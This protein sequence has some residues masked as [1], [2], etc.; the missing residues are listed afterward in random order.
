MPR[1]SKICFSALNAQKM[2]KKRKKKQCSG[3]KNAPGKRRQK[4]ANLNDGE[5]GAEGSASAQLFISPL[6]SLAR[7]K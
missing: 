7:E 4:D 2:K 3:F 1:S 6:Q 5:L